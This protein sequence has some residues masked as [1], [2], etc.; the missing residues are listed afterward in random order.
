MKGNR[1]SVSR[2]HGIDTGV[3]RAR[4]GVSSPRCIAIEH[5]LLSHTFSSWEMLNKHTS[6][7]HR[8]MAFMSPEVLHQ[9]K[10][11]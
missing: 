9:L 4:K 7:N 8:R 2:S 1:H 11:L 10:N 6:S 3:V 5:R